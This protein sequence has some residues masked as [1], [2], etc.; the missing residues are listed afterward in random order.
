MF[1]R[2]LGNLTK[3]C[4]PYVR[5]LSRLLFAEV[6]AVV[7]FSQQLLIASDHHSQQSSPKP[8]G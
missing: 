5:L 3:H 2:H 1:E 6:T 4:L 8:G 7:S